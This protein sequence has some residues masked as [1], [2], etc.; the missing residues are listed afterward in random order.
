M[1]SWKENVT[2]RASPSLWAAVSADDRRRELMITHARLSNSPRHLAKGS[3]SAKI[4]EET[5]GASGC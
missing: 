2:K 3:G 1:L 5:A 4:V